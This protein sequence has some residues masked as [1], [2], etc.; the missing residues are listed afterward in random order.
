MNLSLTKDKILGSRGISAKDIF[1][2]SD[3]KIKLGA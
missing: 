1:F 2:E 3:E